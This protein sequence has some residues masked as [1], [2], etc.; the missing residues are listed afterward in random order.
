MLSL[1]YEGLITFLLGGSSLFVVTGIWLY[2]KVTSEKNSLRY[3]RNSI[4]FLYAPIGLFLAFVFYALWI[5]YRDVWMNSE[6][7][8]YELL[9]MIL[10]I[11]S[12]IGISIFLKKNVTTFTQRK[13]KILNILSITLFVGYILVFVLASVH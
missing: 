6:K 8:G 2:S 10:Y 11:G 13:A 7:E 5:D 1:S 9:A 4:L 12:L 3:Y